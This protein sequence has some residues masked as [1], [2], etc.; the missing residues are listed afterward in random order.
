[1]KDL[2]HCT[3]TVFLILKS[4]ENL[5]DILEER[6]WTNGHLIETLRQSVEVFGFLGRRFRSA[7]L[8]SLKCCVDDRV[9][10]HVN[11]IAPGAVDAESSSPV[12][13]ADPRLELGMF[14]RN[15]Q[16]PD[17][18]SILASRSEGAMKS[19]LDA[20]THPGPEARV[21]RIAGRVGSQGAAA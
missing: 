12:G 15:S 5:S 14:W 16:I 13:L 18:V 2:T 6:T 21:P 7:N 4:V 3:E 17:R 9:V 19:S 10:F 1:M 20:L 11:E 8:A